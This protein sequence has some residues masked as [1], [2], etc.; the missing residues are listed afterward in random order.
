MDPESD[1]EE[2]SPSDWLELANGGGVIFRD[3]SAIQR[4][5]PE[6]Y[7]GRRALKQLP[8]TAASP[9]LDWR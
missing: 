4:S 9:R 5:Q 7:V 8:T 6:K 3:A 2:Q 1:V